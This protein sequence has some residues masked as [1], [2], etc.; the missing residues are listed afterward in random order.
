MG[1]VLSPLSCDQRGQLSPLP[2]LPPSSS[3][4]SPT[5][6]LALGNKLSS[7]R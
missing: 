3:S 4:C 1:P 7:V 6:T 2:T 5:L